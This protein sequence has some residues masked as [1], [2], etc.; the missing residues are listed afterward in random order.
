MDY[1][2]YRF[3]L[4]PYDESYSDV[5]A[6]EL[7]AAGFDSFD[8][9]GEVLK[10]YIQSSLIDNELIEGVIQNFPIPGINISYTYSSVV[11]AD[12]NS[13][14]ES[15]FSPIRIGN[16]I[17]IHDERE[18]KANDVMYDILIHPRMAFGSGSHSTTRLMLQLLLSPQ[19]GEQPE[20]TELVPQDLF[21]KRVLDVGC[22]TGIL[23]IAALKGGCDHLTALDIDIDSVLNTQENLL[24]NEADGQEVIEGELS[25]L[26]ENEH[27]DLILSNIHLNVH[28][29]QMN[30]YS[31]HLE[32]GG[33]LL[34]SGFFVDESETVVIAAGVNGLRKEREMTEDEWCAIEFIK[35]NE[36]ENGQK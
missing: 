22:G 10:G 24:L 9:D 16:L 26:D 28:L 12:W 13:V 32:T 25:M 23:G 33:R 30:L 8:T 5:L 1:T 14:W 3:E 29:S 6:S 18:E 21:G 2:E 15:G 7:G 27:Y 11:S 31:K 34:L 19:K 35:L 36:G 17:H 20:S 4:N